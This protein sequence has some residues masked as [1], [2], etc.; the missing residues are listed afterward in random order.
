MYT[1][2]RGGGKGMALAPCSVSLHR[3]GCSSSQCQTS[4]LYRSDCSKYF[5]VTSPLSFIELFLSPDRILL[6][7]V[8]DINHLFSKTSLLLEIKSVQVMWHSRK[9]RVKL[10]GNGF[11]FELSC[12][13]AARLGKLFTSS[14]L[15]FVTCKITTLQNCCEDQ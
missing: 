1:V 11:E 5:P 13:P 6:T 2:Q 15:R 14:G 3:K 4:N 7:C 12:S 8:L 10:D 9:S